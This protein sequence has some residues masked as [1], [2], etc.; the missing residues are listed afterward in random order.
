[1]DFKLIAHKLMPWVFTA[2]FFSGISTFFFTYQL[3]TNVDK[4][5]MASER[6]FQSY[7]VADELR[8]SSDDLTRLVRTFVITNNEDYEKMFKEVIAIRDGISPRPT[9]YHQIYWDL[10]MKFGE[11]P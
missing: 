6:R 5:Q 10:M 2:I 4:L 11:K 3:F 9:N 8:Q 1:M 7:L